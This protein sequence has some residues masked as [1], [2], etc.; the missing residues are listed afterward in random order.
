MN[1]SDVITSNGAL[2]LAL[3]ER[4]LLVECPQGKPFLGKDVSVMVGLWVLCGP[5][6]CTL[7]L[8]VKDRA[9][10]RETSNSMIQTLGIF[11]F[12]P[13]VYISLEHLGHLYNFLLVKW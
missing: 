9:T 7:T 11:F 5:M 8:M 10:C 3:H 12:F 1:H 4:M 13:Y 2:A 6:T